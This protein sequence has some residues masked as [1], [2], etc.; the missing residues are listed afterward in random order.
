VV[1]YFVSANACRFEL[2][3]KF[4]ENVSFHC[5]EAQDVE[6]E[7]VY[8][9][10]ILL[11]QFIVADINLVTISDTA[12]YFWCVGLCDFVVHSVEQIL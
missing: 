4:P 11:T 3:R 6:Y 2:H 12:R 7:P 9:R 8:I 5:A 10:I 1:Q